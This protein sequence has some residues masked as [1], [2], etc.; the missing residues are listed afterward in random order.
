MYCYLGSFQLKMHHDDAFG[1]A[2]HK[3][4]WCECDHGDDIL[5]TFGSPFSPVKLTLNA[6]FTEDEKQLSKE[7]MTYLTN[8]AKTG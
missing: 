1:D 7:F 2:L 8:F 4:D 6:K 3:P 5:M